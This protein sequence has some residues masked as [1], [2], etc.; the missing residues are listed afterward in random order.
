MSVRKRTW[1][2]GGAIKE[3]WIVEYRGTDGKPHIKTFQK[4]REA[5]AYHAVVGISVRSGLHVAD[6]QSKTVGEAARAYLDHCATTGLE[7]TTLVYYTQHVELH[8]L[9]VL[10]TSLRLSQLT[11]PALRAFEDKLG[12]DRSPVMVRRVIGT[13][14][15]ILADAQERGWVSHNVVRD[16]RQKREHQRGRQ[17]ERRQSGKLKIG[18]DIPTPAEIRQLIAAV[19][20]RWRPMI[21]TA[22]FTGLRASE[23]RGLTWANVDLKRAELHV[24]QRADRYNK[25]GP[26]KSADGERTVPIPPALLQELRTWKLACPRGDLGLVFPSGTGSIES[27]SN[28]LQRGL[29]PAMI[30]AKLT[31]RNERHETVAKYSGLHNLRHFFASWCINR[32]VDG[33]LELPSKTVQAR[34][35]HSSI[36]ITFDRYG[37]LFP[38]GDDSAELAAAEAV[39]FN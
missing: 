34:M 29:Q 21:L 30:A 12:V 35:G 33:G 39:L 26:P 8:L 2:N 19:D 17:V 25:M 27:L 5:D 32:C 36:Q 9:P 28:I 22:I 24:R 38:R 6:S 3:A 7:R 16:L 37:H 23:L 11:L 15:R 10:G 4:K 13:L 31:R 18:V 14:G 20:G 1:E